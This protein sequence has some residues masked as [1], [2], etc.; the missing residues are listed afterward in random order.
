MGPQYKG[1]SGLLKIMRITSVNFMLLDLPNPPGSKEITLLHTIKGI[2]LRYFHFKT[3]RNFI[4]T[5]N[6]TF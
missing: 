5:V 1:E 2:R 4:R 6:I 3:Y